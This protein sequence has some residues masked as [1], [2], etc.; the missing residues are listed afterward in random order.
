MEPK[1]YYILEVRTMKK[2]KE[3][4]GKHKKEIWYGLVGTVAVCGVVGGLSLTCLRGDDR[5]L[6]EALKGFGN[7]ERGNTLV[8]NILRAQAG[9]NYA[10]A[11]GKFN[12]PISV[13]E[14][15]GESGD[16]IFDMNGYDLEKSK[17]IGG[18]FFVNRVK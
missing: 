14:M 3:F 5:K 12:Q 13:A 10:S 8:K 2:I 9:S 16:T 7:D 6:I 4:W 1:G 18:V 15:I 17:L 11:F